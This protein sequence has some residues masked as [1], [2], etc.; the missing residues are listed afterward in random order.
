MV[1]VG[2]GDHSTRHGPPR[3][4]V[5]VARLAVQP[6]F[7]R[8]EEVGS[9]HPS[10]IPHSPADGLSRFLGRESLEASGPMD[11]PGQ[12]LG[13]EACRTVGLEDHTDQPDQ[14]AIRGPAQWV[15]GMTVTQ[16]EP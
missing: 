7:G 3:V 6:Q 14:A 1:G 13:V 2:V 16:M 9:V 5:E 12:A 8:S 4:D 10:I 11:F 15:E